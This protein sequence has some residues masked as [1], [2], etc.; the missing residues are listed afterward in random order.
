MHYQ[1]INKI[2]L[3]T[4]SKSIQVSYFYLLSNSVTISVV[5]KVG[6]EEKCSFIS[7]ILSIYSDQEY[8]FKCGN[9]QNYVNF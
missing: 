5:M 6:D 8:F 4:Q 1:K 7:F 2:R 9:S 3:N